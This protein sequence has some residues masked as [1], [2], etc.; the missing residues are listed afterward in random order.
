MLDEILI[1]HFA[2]NIIQPEKMKSS[3]WKER[4]KSMRVHYPDPYHVRTKGVRK[5]LSSR[6]TEIKDEHLL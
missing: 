3:K 2:Q 6:S 1:G 4:L 5:T